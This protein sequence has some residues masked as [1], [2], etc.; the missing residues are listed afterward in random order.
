M[1]QLLKY[2]DQTIMFSWATCE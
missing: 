1:Q 2:Y